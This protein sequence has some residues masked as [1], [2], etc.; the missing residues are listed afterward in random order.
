MQVDPIE[1]IVKSARQLA[2]SQNDAG[3]YM[4]FDAALNS[5]EFPSQLLQFGSIYATQFGD[6]ALT[7][8]FIQALSKEGPA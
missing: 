2:A 8:R 7:A 6:T 4:R 1:N 5:G 3:A